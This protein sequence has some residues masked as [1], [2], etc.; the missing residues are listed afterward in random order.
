MNT[1]PPTTHSLP[2]PQ[3]LRLMRSTRKLTALLGATPFLVDSDEHLRTSK[4]S[5]LE[6][7]DAK[8]YR[9]AS[10]A[11]ILS[12]GGCD[13]C[14]SPAAL[15]SVLSPQSTQRPTLLLRLNASTTH[16]NHRH[17]TSEGWSRPA[18][19]VGSLPSPISAKHDHNDGEAYVGRATR[20]KKMARITRTLGEN[21]PP[22]L[23]FTCAGPPQ[24]TSHNRK[25]S[26]PSET[27]VEEMKSRLSLEE[28]E[29]AKIE[30]APLHAADPPVPGTDSSS[31]APPDRGFLQSIRRSTSRKRS[32]SRSTPVVMRMETGWIGEWNQDE[33]TVV[34]T[35]RELKP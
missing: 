26:F 31:V 27:P 32:N 16:V 6:P 5:P 13:H 10:I 8:E 7:L 21:V 19:L 11:S 12:S 24:R 9:R 23:V 14:S 35:L 4:K 29:F 15:V 22:E 18:S 20:R 3:R 28:V 1:L 30:L 25:S 33:V 17:T 34:K 2:K